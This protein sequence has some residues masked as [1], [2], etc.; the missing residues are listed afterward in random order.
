MLKQEKAYFEKIKTALEYQGNYS[1]VD[2]LLIQH[3]AETL[4][5]LDLSRKELDK[6]GRVQKFKTGATQISPE[7]N[8]W[9]GL[10][11]DFMKYCDQLGLSPKARKS[12]GIEAKKKELPK[13][14]FKLR[15]AE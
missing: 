13:N 5:Q 14:P 4:Y 10:K 1:P 11:Q 12:I 2:D 8:N 6:T 9:R 15:K 3:A 7:L